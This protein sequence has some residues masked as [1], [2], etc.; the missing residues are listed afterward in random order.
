MVLFFPIC[1]SKLGV[2][3]G[4]KH[5]VIRGKY[6]PSFDWL[7]HP[8]AIAIKIAG[9][10][11]KIKILK[12][13]FFL[14]NKFLIQNCKIKFEYKK[15]HIII[16][17]SNNFSIAR[18]RVKINGSKSTIIYDGYKKNMLLK[19]TKKDKFY[20]KIYYKKL[21]P[22]QNLLN[23]FYLNIKSKSI[24]NDMLFSHQVM[25]ILIFIERQINNR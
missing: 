19:K 7:P 20:K 9:Y 17:F 25:K 16:D 6:N 2:S 11:S 8:I 4:K 23:K 21:H 3:F 13:N 5:R 18:R 1:C 10:P 22:I 14:K 24:H 15:F 12:N